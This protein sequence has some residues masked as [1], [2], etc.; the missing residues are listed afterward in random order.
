[1]TPRERVLR[2]VTFGTPDRV[3]LKHNLTGS[4]VLRHGEALLEILA[5]YPDDYGTDTTFPD[6]MA[7]RAERGGRIE[8][9]EERTDE[10]GCTWRHRQDGI[11]GMVTCRPLEDWSALDGYTP[12]PVP[13]C[14]PEL[15]AQRRRA[16]DERRK[17]WYTYGAGCMIWERMQF[18]RG[19]ASILM[20]LADGRPEVERL[21]DMLFDYA[22]RLFEPSLLAGCDGVDVGDDW[23]NQ[24][25]LRIRPESWRRVFRPRYR[26]LFQFVHQHRAHVRFHTCGHVLEILP[27]LIEVGVDVLN[28][29]SSCMPLDELAR[30]ARG[31]VCLE[32][33]I[34]RQYEMPHGTPA[35]VRRRTKECFD[36]LALPAGAFIW[37]TE[38]GPDV[39]LENVAA[40]YEACR[41][42]GG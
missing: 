40:Y 2:A 39:P 24:A 6:L 27:E 41:E 20:D 5:R 32:V 38:I 25:Q 16:F 42:L 22:R 10:W 1:M 11:F 37:L 7:R 23:G 19:D 18:L 26:E 29:Q 8:T 4:A 21:A 3:P 30:L 33:D 9:D 31:K 12:P 28:I 34:D 15:V 35:D 14:T 13:E 36:A 17:T